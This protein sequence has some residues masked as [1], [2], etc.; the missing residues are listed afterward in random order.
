VSGKFAGTV[1][2]L[3]ANDSQI[4]S[5]VSDLVLG[6]SKIVPIRHDHVRKL[7]DLDASLLAFLVGELGHVLGPHP[8]RGFAIEAIATRIKLHSSNSLAG[9]K[10][11]ERNPRIVG[12]NARGVGARGDLH[13]APQN[14]RDWWRRLGRP[15]AISFNEIFALIGHSVLEGDPAKQAR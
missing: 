13:T 4:G 7:A 6:A 3:S 14:L 15:V 10:P 8:Q 11:G 5:R 1:N 9:D 12:R 2:D